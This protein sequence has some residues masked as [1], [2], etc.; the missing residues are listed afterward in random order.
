M[1]TVLIVVFGSNKW[2]QKLCGDLCDNS[3]WLEVFSNCHKQLHLRFGKDSGSA[4]VRELNIDLDP[5]LKF[6]ILSITNLKEKKQ[7]QILEKISTDY[8]FVLN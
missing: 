5:K 1:L 6:A 4:S 7:N 2:I 3:F 8:P